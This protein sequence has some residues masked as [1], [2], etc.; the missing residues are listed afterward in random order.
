MEASPAPQSL[1][2]SAARGVLS[3]G[4]P[5]C[6]PLLLCSRSPCGTELGTMGDLRGHGPASS[7]QGSQK[8]SQ[9]PEPSVHHGSQLPSSPEL[10]GVS[11]WRHANWSGPGREGASP[12]STPQPQSCVRQTLQLPPARMPVLQSLFKPVL[13]DPLPSSSCPDPA[14]QGSTC[15][16]VSS[17]VPGLATAV[18][19]GPSHLPSWTKTCTVGL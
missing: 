2:A 12:A 19:L 9:S 13:G 16:A 17:S 11:V 14:L 15:Y 4:R 6:H 5:P 18:S 1:W 3:R 10:R 8:S 7:A